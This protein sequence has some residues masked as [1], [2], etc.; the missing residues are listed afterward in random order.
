METPERGGE[1]LHGMDPIGRFTNRSADYA[2]Y[3]PAYPAAAIDAILSG[4][5]DPSWLVAADVGAGTG[6]SAR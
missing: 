2:R 1:P 4:R 3:R 6:I 5:P